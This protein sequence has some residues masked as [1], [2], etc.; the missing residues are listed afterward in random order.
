MTFNILEYNSFVNEAMNP[1]S[2]LENLVE[3]VRGGAGWIDP[4]HAIEIFSDLTGIPADDRRIDSML[5][6][7]SGLDYLY[8]ENPDFPGKKGEKAEFEKIKL[9]PSPHKAPSDEIPQRS[10]MES[11][12]FRIKSLHEF[13]F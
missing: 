13:G 3:I 2:A 5:S 12:N 6:I 7:L 10:M 4:D 1:K 8:Y 11:L 9:S